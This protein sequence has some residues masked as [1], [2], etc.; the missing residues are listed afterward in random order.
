VWEAY[1][2]LQ[3]LARSWLYMAAGKRR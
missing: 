1:Q 3:P 2:H